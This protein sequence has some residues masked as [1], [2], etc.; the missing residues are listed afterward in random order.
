MVLTSAAEAVPGS[1]RVCV[2]ARPLLPSERARGEASVLQCTDPKQISVTIPN[3][4]GA[5]AP[6]PG[7]GSHGGAGGAASSSRLATTTLSRA[8]QFDL[9]CHE[10]FGQVPVFTHCG[11]SRLVEAS[12]EGV[13]ATILAYGATNSGKTYTMSGLEQSSGGSDAAGGAVSNGGGDG[14]GGDAEAHAGLITQAAR[15]L[16]A[17]AAARKASGGWRYTVTASYCEVP[18]TLRCSLK[19]RIPFGI[20]KLTPLIEILRRSHQCG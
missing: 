1:V 10:G 9:A 16:Y 4:Q 2:R 15:H 18:E 20:A 11:A 12:L 13:K 8:F 5:S 6:T 3:A 7:L 14:A 17:K 19:G